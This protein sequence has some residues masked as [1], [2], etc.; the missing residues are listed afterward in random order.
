[1]SSMIALASFSS[2]FVAIMPSSNLRV[3]ATSLKASVAIV[4]PISEPRH[5]LHVHFHNLRRQ[6]HCRCLSLWPFF[7]GESTLLIACRGRLLGVHPR[8]VDGCRDLA[9]LF[10]PPIG[11]GQSAPRG[12]CWLVQ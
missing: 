7:P 10:P 12:N 5:R 3:S 11:D 8:I 6:N 4:V 9:P 2:R 1:M